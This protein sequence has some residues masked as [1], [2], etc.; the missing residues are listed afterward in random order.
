MEPNNIPM[1]I[2][3]FFFKLF[4]EQIS[5][6]YFEKKIYAC[7]KLEHYDE[8]LYLELIS[9]NFNDKE[10]IK[11]IK[12]ISFPYLDFSLYEKRGLIKKLNSLIKLDNDFP[13]SLNYIYQMSS[14]E[15][16]FLEDLENYIYSLTYEIGVF[17]DDNWK[18]YSRYE[19]QQIVEK[20]RENI[21]NECEN[22]L[23][24]IESQ[25]IVLSGKHTKDKLLS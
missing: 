4:E 5:V 13:N 19:R 10:I 22:L 12:D 3:I 21:N 18:N 7:K 16:D 20:F 25:K 17:Y 2:Q 15:Y 8:K 24:K 11:K 9:V 1:F 6:R 23:N 14:K